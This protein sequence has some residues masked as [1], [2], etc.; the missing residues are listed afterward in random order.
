MPGPT[1]T[2]DGTQP[3]ALGARTWWVV[4]VVGLVGQLAWTIENMYL[5][6]FVYERISPDPAVIAAMVA[7]SA[8]AATVAAM[9]VGAW[10]DRVGAR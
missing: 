8:V 7:I 9:L 10:S 2:R 4:V 3:P 5:N 1:P 6:L